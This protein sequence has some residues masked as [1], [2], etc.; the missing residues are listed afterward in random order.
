MRRFLLTIIA[1][2]IAG[3][4]FAAEKTGF[5]DKVYKNKDGH[6]SPYVVFV[7]ASYDGSKPM[8]TILFLHGSGETKG[9]SKMPVEVGLP[10]VVKKKEKEF[11]FI[12]VIP[13]SE[14][15]TWLAKSEDGERAL[16]ILAEVEKAY[17]CDPK[18]TYL[19]GLSMGGMGTLS[20]ATA[21]PAKWAA[22]VPVCGRMIPP[23]E[24]EKAGEMLKGIPAWF[25]HG[26]KDTAVKVDGS[27]EMV[28]AIKKAG[29]QPKY[30]EYP[31]VPH[32]CWDKAYGTDELYEWLLKQEK[33]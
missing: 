2:T 15:R 22:I 6:D 8:P 28:A 26:D 21:N 19:T 10:P 7:P 30:T 29:G 33:K 27:R 17:K 24:T 1:V 23:A 14:K 31:N 4:A 16:A 5:I 12:V 9:G 13:Q 20:L 3:S 11:P 25:F 18:R 32:N